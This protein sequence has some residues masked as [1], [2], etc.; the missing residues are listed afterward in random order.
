[1]NTS[2]VM[3]VAAGALAVVLLFVAYSS[4]REHD[5]VLPRSAGVASAAPKPAPVVQQDR[6]SFEL[7]DAQK[8]AVDRALEMHRPPS[9]QGEFEYLLLNPSQNKLK[10]TAEQIQALQDAY[11]HLR[12]ARFACEASI[13]KVTAVDGGGVKIDI[14]AYPDRGAAL[15]RSF[16]NE[17][18]SKVGADVGNEIVAEYGDYIAARNADYGRQLQSYLATADTANPGYT[19]VV[20][21]WSQPDGMKGSTVSQVNRGNYFFFGALSAFFPDN[22]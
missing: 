6:A 16:D 18:A 2:K 9:T 11:D 4:S 20:L 3:K 12:V 5:R 17:L 13:A 14:P 21:N 7:T 15:E 8:A 10:L 1:M 22:K 19:K